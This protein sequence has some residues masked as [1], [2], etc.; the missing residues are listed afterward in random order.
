MSDNELIYCLI[1]FILGWLASRHMGNGYSVREQAGEQ[2]CSANNRKNISDT[3]YAPA[4]N[5]NDILVDTMDKAK[6]ICPTIY[7]E[8]WNPFE[9]DYI[10]S[11]TNATRYG[12]R[13][14]CGNG[15]VCSRF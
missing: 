11:S 7:T 13:Y 10:C 5:C 9:D 14:A 3:I 4:S 15:E 8:T 6:E 1:T 2:K 12:M